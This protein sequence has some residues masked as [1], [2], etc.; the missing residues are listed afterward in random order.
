[1]SKTFYLR[2][3]VKVK[4][5]ILVFCG[6]LFVG[7][8]FI[9]IVVPG[10]PTTPFMILAAFCFVKSSDKLYKWVTS[11][12]LFG[13]KVKR[14]LDDRTLSLRSKIMCLSAMWF[15]TILSFIFLIGKMWIGILVGLVA[16]A[17]TLFILSIKTTR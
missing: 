12:K 2:H 14:F 17:G 10:L 3:M 13:A 15:M 7:L 5:A 16:V 8:G 11:N 4:K 6:V 1:M 9:G